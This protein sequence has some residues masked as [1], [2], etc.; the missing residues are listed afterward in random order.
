MTFSLVARCSRTGELGVAVATAIPAV[1]AICPFA[2]A[3]VGAISSQSY[4]N[5]LYGPDGLALLSDGVEPEQ[6]LQSLT[7]GDPGRSL[8]QV[9]MVDAKGRAAAFTGADCVDAHRHLVGNGFAAAGNMLTDAT[10]VDAVARAFEAAAGEV[11]S[12]RL[13][14]ALEAGQAAGGDKRGRQSAALLVVA[15]DEFAACDL[16]VDEHAEPV[17]ELRRVYEVA[18][19]QLLP[20]IRSMPTRTNP[21]GTADPA[22]DAYLLRPVG[23]R[24]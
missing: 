15:A 14:R 21:A 13:I 7:A 18:K 20:F 19:R 2:R 10:V 17:A 8:R 16:R 22:L 9:V 5:A 11:L 4:T 6:A 3:G 23:E 12:E 1:G 24:G